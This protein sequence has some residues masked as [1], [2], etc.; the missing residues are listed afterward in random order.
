MRIARA[1]LLLGLTG[2][3]GCSTG[4]AGLFITPGKYDSKSCEEIVKLRKSFAD[5]EFE[6]TG[7]MEK[8]SRDRTG[9]VA[10]AVGYAPELAAARSEVRTADQALADKGCDTRVKP[11]G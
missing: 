11:P 3:A 10:N 5:R 1:V 8:A 7:L 4:A 2:L 6:L 9:V